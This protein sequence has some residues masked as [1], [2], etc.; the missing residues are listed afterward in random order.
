MQLLLSDKGYSEEDTN[1]LVD[2]YLGG[3]LRGHTSHGLASFPGFVKQDFSKQDEPVVLKETHSTF[4]IDAKSNPGALIGKRAAD[5]AIARANKEVIGTALIKNMDSWLRPGAIAQYIAEQGYMTLVF[6]DGGGTSIAPPG[7]YDPVLATNPIAYGIPTNGAPLVVDMATSKR[8]WGQVRLANKYDTDLP[9]DTFYNNRGELTRNPK[10]AH[11]VLP[12][13]D[14]KGFAL[15]MMIEIMC[16]SLVGM[17]NMMLET[18]QGGSNFGVKLQERGGFILVID[19]R[20]TT[21]LDTFKK[22]NSELVEKIKATSKLSDEEI[23]IPGEQ[24]SKL[25]D[26]Y[27]KNDSIDIPDELWEEIQALEF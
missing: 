21:D 18:N 11:S 8:A 26:E 24:A 17:D 23:R 10:E 13:G 9:E 20:Q 2:M 7:G 6:N 5:E 25:Q 4:I 22:A 15:A 27:L 19:P 3:E 1:F 16:G 12:F 14:Y